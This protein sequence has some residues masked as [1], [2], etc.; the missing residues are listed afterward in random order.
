MRFLKGFG[1]FLFFCCFIGTCNAIRDKG[2]GHQQM[3]SVPQSVPMARPQPVTP[4]PQPAPTEQHKFVVKRGWTTPNLTVEVPE[5]VSK[6]FEFSNFKYD[7]GKLFANVVWFKSEA[8]PLQSELQ[9]RY[10]AYDSEGV[11]VE[12]DVI[13]YGELRKGEK[14]KL[15][16]SGRIAPEVIRVVVSHC[17]LHR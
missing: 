12:T 5:D 3:A 6:Y 17:Y 10:D 14:S 8:E 15:Q 1:V 2:R 16:F 7:N 9:L 13:P 4:V 11:R